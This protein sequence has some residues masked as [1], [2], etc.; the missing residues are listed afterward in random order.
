MKDLQ[1]KHDFSL[2]HNLW[3]T[4]DQKGVWELK[5]SYNFDYCI[6]RKKI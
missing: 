6:F 5:K 2:W 3:Y 4:N 1:I